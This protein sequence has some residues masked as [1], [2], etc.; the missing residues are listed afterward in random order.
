MSKLLE[1]MFD[2]MEFRL[3]RRSVLQQKRREVASRRRKNITKSDG[4]F[5]SQSSVPADTLDRG[6]AF[7]KPGLLMKLLALLVV[8]LWSAGSSS[9][10]QQLREMFHNVEQSVV[11]V[12]T[13]EK[14]LAPFPQQGFVSMNGLGSGVLISNDGKVLTAAHLVRSADKTQ[15]EFA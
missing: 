3:A 11:I 13:E 1:A 4:S 7:K 14:G 12:R 15:V 6:R 2:E 5:Q 8:T 9:Y 10:G